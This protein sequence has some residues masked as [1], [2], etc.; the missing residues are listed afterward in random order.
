MR[1]NRMYNKWGTLVCTYLP[2]AWPFQQVSLSLVVVMN[3][4]ALH[5]W[6]GSLAQNCL[7]SLTR[8]RISLTSLSR[9]SPARSRC[10]PLPPTS[11]P[12]SPPAPL[13]LRLLATST[14]RGSRYVETKLRLCLS[15]SRGLPPQPLNTCV[16][17]KRPVTELPVIIIYTDNWYQVHRYNGN[18][19]VHLDKGLDL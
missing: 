9:S 16:Q 7:V 12:R 15:P 19:Q 8:A 3:G 14:V 4:S 17:W 6:Y 11:V 1:T 10:L 13:R 5:V 2:T 18:I